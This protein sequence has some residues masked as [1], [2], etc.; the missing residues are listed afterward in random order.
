MRSKV[1]LEEFLRILQEKRGNGLFFTIFKKEPQNLSIRKLTDEFFILLKPWLKDTPDYLL[2]N[3]SLK[4]LQNDINQKTNQKTRELVLDII[5][6]LLTESHRRPFQKIVAQSPHLPSDSIDYLIKHSLHFEILKLLSANEALREPHFKALC[7]EKR[8]WELFPILAR[9]KSIPQ[10]LVYRFIQ[11][12]REAISDSLIQNPAVSA[13][14]KLKILSNHNDDFYLLMLLAEQ[15]EL[16]KDDYFWDLILKALN[17][18]DQ[19]S[20]LHPRL[21]Y[22]NYKFPDAILRKQ[23]KFLKEENRLKPSSATK[24]LLEKVEER[25]KSS[26]T[27][28]NKLSVIF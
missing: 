2:W 27:S 20:S 23:R 14:Q 6:S 10:P 1:L 4:Q 19:K 9:N 26:S 24:D 16:P 17:E 11:L 7:D 21:F 3:T 13:K 28:K 5:Y 12:K 15:K 18:P 22:K 8:S 25:L